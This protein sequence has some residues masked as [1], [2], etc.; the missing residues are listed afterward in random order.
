MM[1]DF[2]ASPYGAYVWPA[3]AITALVFA[4][5]IA[6]ALAHARRW[7]AR[8]EALRRTA[9]AAEAAHRAAPSKAPAP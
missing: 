8:T 5:M 9:E 1:L 6:A 2:D 3:F 7:R 4:G